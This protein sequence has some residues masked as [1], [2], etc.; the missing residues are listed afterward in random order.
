MVAEGEPVDGLAVVIDGDLSGYSR[1]IN[2]SMDL[3]TKFDRSLQE[4]SGRRIKLAKSEADALSAEST[5]ATDHGSSH[6]GY[7][8]ERMLTHAGTRAAEAAIGRQ[9]AEE[10]GMVAHSFM[11]LTPPIALAVTAITLLT[12]SITEYKKELEALAEFHHKESEAAIAMNQWMEKII[13]GPSTPFGEQLTGRAQELE[14]GVRERKEAHRK[15]DQE[16]H[17]FRGVVDTASDFVALIGDTITGNSTDMNTNTPQRKL[18]WEQAQQ[19]IL[20]M[21]K[22]SN[23]KAAAK[24]ELGDARSRLDEERKFKIESAGYEDGHLSATAKKRAELDLSH[25]KELS[26]IDFKAVQKKHELEKAVSL[27]NKAQKEADAESSYWTGQFQQ[28]RDA[29][30]RTYHAKGLKLDQEKAL[31]NLGYAHTL[32]DVQLSGMKEGYAKEKALMDEKY[33]SERAAA[34]AAHEDDKFI[35]LVKQ[36]GAAQGALDEKY[37]RKEVEA[38]RDAEIQIAK[39]RHEDT[40]GMELDK[41]R[42]QLALEHLTT[43]EIEKRVKLKQTEIWLQQNEALIR[44][45]AKLRLEL[46]HLGKAGV[47][48]TYNLSKARLDNPNADPAEINKQVKAQEALTRA[49]AANKIAE[50]LHPIIGFNERKAELDDLLKNSQITGN[51]YARELMK[52]KQK[53]ESEAGFERPGQVVS[54]SSRWQQIQSR[55]S[56]GGAKPI[57]TAADEAT[58]KRAF[59]GVTVNIA[60]GD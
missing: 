48:H 19:D 42:E 45:T 7:R 9:G 43:E 60:N 12:G 18:E 2:A 1:V 38:V 34:R 47:D 50:E 33:E 24:V 20:D 53:A 55:I 6:L 36:Q 4:A 8:G 32:R 25:R 29:A 21:K 15:D 28:D 56:E 40:T 41:F 39:L 35:E 52:A 46:E 11:T 58:M 59:T 30:D 57:L 26:E 14:K 27:G 13:Q 54:M 23:M 17:F 16:T 22:A 44:S 51:D 10:L 5:Q 31:T 49:Q 3:T 37:G